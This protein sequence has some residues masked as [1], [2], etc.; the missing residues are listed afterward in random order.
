M[1][2]IDG[3]GMEWTR[4]IPEHTIDKTV[5]AGASKNRDGI[6]MDTM[7]ISVKSMDSKY[8]IVLDIREICCSSYDYPSN[9]R[10]R[11]F[12]H[13]KCSDFMAKCYQ[14]TGLCTSRTLTP[15]LSTKTEEPS[16]LLKQKHSVR[17]YLGSSRSSTIS[18]SECKNPS[19][20]IQESR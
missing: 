8:V 11:G 3:Q 17:P 18:K 5:C 19:I 12:Q 9:L 14:S 4:M 16:L 2:L 6:D 15:S 10:A 7:D 20:E 1:Q 13:G